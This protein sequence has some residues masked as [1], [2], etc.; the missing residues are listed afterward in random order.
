MQF[1]E[2][3]Y[4]A[5]CENLKALQIKLTYLLNERWVFCL[6]K[7]NTHKI[8]TDAF[9]QNC[10]CV[11]VRSVCEVKRKPILNLKKKNVST[12]YQITKYINTAGCWRVLPFAISMPF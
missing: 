11:R 2:K 9:D 10:T 6:Q 7:K 1:S 4:F 12:K 3:C 5:K 8:V